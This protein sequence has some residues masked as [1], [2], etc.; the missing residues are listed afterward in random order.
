MEHS[1]WKSMWKEIRLDR[2]AMAGLILFG[3]MIAATYIGSLFIDENLM[4]A[5]NTARIF[6]HPQL[7]DPFAPFGFDNLGRNIFHYLVIGARTSFNIAFMVTGLSVAF[8]M[9]VGLLA[10]YFGGFFDW[11]V[12][13]I[14]DFFAMVPPILIFVIIVIAVG[15]GP[16]G[17]AVMMAAFSWAG[18]AR[19][20]RAMSLKQGALEYVAASKTLGTPNFIV[21]FREVLPNLVSIVTANLTLNLAANVGIET[22]LTMLGLGLPHGYPSLGRLIYFGTEARHIQDRWWLWV[23]AALVVIIMM[24]CIN[25]VGQALNRAADAKK[26]TI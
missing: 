12:M 22:G 16:I 19:L 5:M 9:V 15:P 17:F 8:G 24:L 18:T 4:R 6:G 21:I 3:L 13:R 20:I 26:R 2:L 14:L 7:S 23:P 25:F 11:I 1:L 10:G